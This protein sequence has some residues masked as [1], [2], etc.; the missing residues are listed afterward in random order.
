VRCPA[1]IRAIGAWESELG[2]RIDR[3]AALFATPD[4]EVVVAGRVGA[5]VWSFL[6]TQ[7]ACRVRLLSEERGMHAAGRDTAG[8]ART[9]LGFLYQQLGPERFFARM[10]ELGQGLILDSRVLLAHLGLR[11]SA[12]DRFASDVFDAAAIAEP[13]LRAFTEAAAAAPIPVL[14]GGHSIVSG[15]L[16]ALSEVAWQQPLSSGRS[17]AR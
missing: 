9:V 5:P 14:L 8:M 17:S 6:E 1:E 4:V 13:R 12:A 16:V 3:I 7:T 15:A 11:P 10:A 2:D